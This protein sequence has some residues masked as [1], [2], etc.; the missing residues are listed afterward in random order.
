MDIEWD[1]E[2]SN[3]GRFQIPELGLLDSEPTLFQRC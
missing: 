3:K 1:I 2:V